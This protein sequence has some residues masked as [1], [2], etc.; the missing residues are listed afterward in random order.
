M[1]PEFFKICKPELKVADLKPAVK[2]MSVR[3]KLKETAN[4]EPELITL[5]QGT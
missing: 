5:R 1:G 2:K 4:R 3:I